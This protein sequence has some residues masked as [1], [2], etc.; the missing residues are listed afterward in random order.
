METIGLPVNLT[1]LPIPRE[2]KT[3]GKKTP[4]HS[5]EEDR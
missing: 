2:S 1:N 5:I 3:N 4:D